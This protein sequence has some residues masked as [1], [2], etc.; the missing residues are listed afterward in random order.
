MRHDDTMRGRIRASWLL[1]AT[2]LLAALPL[3]AGAGGHPRMLPQSAQSRTY[4][5]ECGSCHIAFP[6]RLLSAEGWERVMTSL[7]RHFGTDASVEPTVRAGLAGY[8]RA[9]A[10][11]PR[12]FGTAMRISET[13][14]FRSEHDEVPAGAFKSKEVRSVA[15]CGACHAQAARGDFSEEHVNRREEARR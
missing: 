10:G 5:T 3:G 8:L 6:P 1:V 4:T 14:W 12:R 11:S 9:N 7:E 13:P 2:S 15:N